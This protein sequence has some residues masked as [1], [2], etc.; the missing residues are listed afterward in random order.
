MFCLNPLSTQQ[1]QHKIRTLL[2]GYGFIT[3][4]DWTT[5]L[6]DALL[7][8]NWSWAPSYLTWCYRFPALTI[9]VS[10]FPNLCCVCRQWGGF[11]YWLFRRVMHALL[12]TITPHISI[13]VALDNDTEYALDWITRIDVTPLYILFGDTTY[14][15]TIWHCLSLLLC[16]EHIP[17]SLFAQQQWR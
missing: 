11:G 13:W 16:Q 6:Q 17:S 9:F 4:S 7:G 8:H 10:A 3:D 2:L 15:T 5:T 1:Q 14:E 12:S